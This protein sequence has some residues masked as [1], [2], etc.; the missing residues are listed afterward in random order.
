MVSCG[1]EFIR[2]SRVRVGT[3]Y[4]L[5]GRGRGCLASTASLRPR[6]EARGGAGGHSQQDVGSAGQEA[7]CSSPS[8]CQHLGHWRRLWEDWRKDREKL[9][10]ATCLAHPARESWDMCLGLA[11]P[12]A[13]G[14][15]LSFCQDLHLPPRLPSPSPSSRPQLTV[16][17]VGAWLQMQLGRQDHEEASTPRVFSH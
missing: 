5:R 11:G 13:P 17:G 3:S 7:G 10:E 4:R 8:K 14:P 2:G 16:E 6:K 12:Q 9:R 15:F 1:H